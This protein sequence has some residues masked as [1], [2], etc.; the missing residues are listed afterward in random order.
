MADD[1]NREI[2]DIV[3]G[4]NDETP[5]GSGIF[6][7]GS[8]VLFLGVVM[9]VVVVG[10][11]LSSQN[12]RQPN[13]GTAPEFTLTTFDGETFSLSEQRGNVIVLNF[14]GS[15]CGPCRAETPTLEAIYQAYQDRGV[16]FIGVTYLDEIEDSLAF[17]EEFNVS[18]P[19]GADNQLR[20]S[21]QYRI[22]GAPETF[23]IDQGGKIVEFFYGPIYEG[24]IPP[25]RLTDVLD[26]LLA[27]TES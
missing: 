15:W 18:Y 14:W 13:S 6:S 8:I 10:L 11:Q 26:D 5:Q 17:I 7:L 22:E 25:S 2:D 27:D 20:I 3:Q 9:V 12:T 16:I 23:V 21:D 4:D 1:I 24:S 19:N